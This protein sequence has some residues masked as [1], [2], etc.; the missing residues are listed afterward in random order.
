MHIKAFLPSSLIEFPGRIASVVYVGG[1]NF[2]CP[3]CHNVDLVLHPDRL[4]DLEAPPILRTLKSQM[5]FVDGAVVTGGEPSLHQDLLPFLSELAQ[6]GL[7]TKLDTNGYR[8]DVLAKCIDGGLVDYVAM[9]IKSS[10]EKY[11]LVAGVPLDLGPI[12]ESIALLIGSTVEHEFRT[13]V[14]PTLVA[15]DDAPLIGEMI[16]GAKRY[17]LQSYRPGPT[18]GWG[19]ESPLGPPQADVLRMMAASVS[20]HVCEVG[21]RGHALAGS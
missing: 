15:A 4:T 7:M 8:P 19:A 12:R 13:T 6:M 18:V 21:I 2:R 9:D 20:A 1:C 14:V 10:P 17:Y 11:E 3:Y 16:A 5:G